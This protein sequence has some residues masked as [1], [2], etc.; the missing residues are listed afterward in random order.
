MT[1]RPLTEIAE[2]NQCV[3][4]QR[5]IWGMPDA[6]LLPSRIYVVQNLIGGL[7]LGAFDGDLMIGFLNAMPGV[8]EGM[9][10]WH[11]L[12]L[13]IRRD[14]WN[15]GTG[16]RLKLAQREFAKERGIKLIQWTF[17]PLQSKNAHLNI[18]KLGAIVRRYYV[19]VF[20]SPASTL[21]QGLDSDRLI[22][23]WWIDRPRFDMK[24]DV[25]RLFI[26][27][28]IQSL[29]KQ[30]LKSA[31]DIQLRVREQFMKNLEDDYFAAGFERTDE[32]SAY[33]FIPG[34]S[35]VDQTN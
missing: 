22:A 33:L 34:A 19:N 18:N 14:Y 10:Y 28:D 30:S 25:R 35:C 8:R 32:W 6:E 17:D 9:P 24:A 21:D 15:S 29:K 2:F 12:T 20:G 16:S 13:A 7:V 4:L 11:S 31:Q 26:P 1:I 23:E 27:A 3:E 5:E